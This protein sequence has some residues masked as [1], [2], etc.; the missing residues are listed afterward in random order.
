MAASTSLFTRNGPHVEKILDVPERE[1]AL[2]LTTMVRHLF[3][4]PAAWVDLVDAGSQVVSRI[5]MSPESP[6][7]EVSGLADSAIQPW[8]QPA[9]TAAEPRPCEFP[10]LASAPLVT[11]GDLHLGSLVIADRTS[12]PDFSAEDT[13]ALQELAAA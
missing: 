2:R 3:R 11:S 7:S 8:A 5:G 6:P 1:D 9:R 12:R 4:V 10:F 13:Q